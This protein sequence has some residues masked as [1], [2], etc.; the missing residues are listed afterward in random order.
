MSR[1]SVLTSV[2]LLSILTT[3]CASKVQNGGGSETGFLACAVDTECG[4]DQR[5]VEKKCVERGRQ[6]ALVVATGPV[7]TCDDPQEFSASMPSWWQAE[8]TPSLLPIPRPGCGYNYDPTRPDASPPLGVASA[9]VGKWTAPSDGSYYA[10]GYSRDMPAVFGNASLCG[11]YGFPSQYF[12]GCTVLEPANVPD[13]PFDPTVI[14]G[15]G[16]KLDVKAGEVVYF[17][18]QFLSPDGGAPPDH[19]TVIATIRPY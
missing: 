19:G 3:A 2:T 14:P 10:Y 11:G 18:F 5:C 6:A 17:S 12:G 8:W 4:A 1:W 13:P 9:V 15:G 16:F 7:G